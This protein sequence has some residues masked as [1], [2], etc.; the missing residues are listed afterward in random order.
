MSTD[1]STIPYLPSFANGM[2]NT[3]PV[4]KTDSKDRQL[5]MRMMAHKH[6][7]ET[8][9]RFEWKNLP[10]ELPSDLIERILYFRYKGAFFK[11]NE[12]HYFLPFALKGEIDSYGR[13]IGITPVL[14]TGQWKVSD[15]KITEDISFISGKTFKVV[16]DLDSADGELDEVDLLEFDDKAV[17]LT[18]S[19]L[20]ISQDFTP[21][22]YLIRPIVEQ[23][24]DILVLVNI[25]LISSAKMFYVVAKD[26]EQKEAIEKEFRDLDN[27]ILNGKRVVVL[28]SPTDLKE[29][30]GTS[31]KDTARYF[32]SYQS[33]E[34]LRKDIIGIDNGGT[35]MKQEHTT[36]M[37]TQANTSGGSFVLNNA[38]RMRKEFCEIVNR[39][40]GLSIDVD[41]KGGEKD[42]SIVP[43]GAQTKD[44][45]GG[46]E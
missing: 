7:I 15:G 4:A 44:R 9:E 46:E 24:V 37:E 2:G 11:H 36:E 38:L 17:I 6:M 14:F 39:V 16:Y 35:F 5:L 25:D 18:D 19:S 33:I 12:K 40:F 43:E 23:L 34:N 32:Q 28:T 41:V 21:M 10:P 22:N 42:A 20:E 31:V 27:R 26:P 29:L 3:N 13:Y 45:E 30:M 8:I 1:L